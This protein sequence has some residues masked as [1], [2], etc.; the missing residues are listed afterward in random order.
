VN[1]PVRVEFVTKPILGVNAKGKQ[2]GKS[3]ESKN[4]LFRKMVGHGLSNPDVKYVLADSWFGNS[5]NMKFIKERGRS[6]IFALKS[7]RKVAL[8]LQHKQNGCYTSFNSMRLEGRSQVVYFE[9]LDFPVIITCR[10]FK[11]GGK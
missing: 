7:N 10:V 4:V 11:N 1:V 6:F 9:Q 5:L 8:S 2:V 3:R